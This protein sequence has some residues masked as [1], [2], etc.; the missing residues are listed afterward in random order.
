MVL[1][2]LGRRSRSVTIRN[3]RTKTGNEVATAANLICFV[4]ILADERLN[5]PVW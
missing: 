4:C 3:Y 1:D 5:R 2:G